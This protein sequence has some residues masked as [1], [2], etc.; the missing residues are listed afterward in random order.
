MTGISP[1][2]FDSSR[3]TRFDQLVGNS[4]VLSKIRRMISTS[5]L[6][7]VVFLTG[8]T[9]AG[10][11]TLARIIARALLCN[12]RPTGQYESCG[13]C[14]SCKKDFSDYRGNHCDYQE[15]CANRVD[16][17]FMHENLPSLLS[18]DYCVTFI[19]EIQD[20]SSSDMR[21]L[22][23]QIEGAVGTLIL[24]TTH[25]DLIEDAVRNRLKSYEYT[26]IRPTTSEIADFLAGVFQKLG[27]TYSGRVE[28][29]RVANFYKCEMR[30]CGEFP[31]KVLREY[32]TELTS[33]YLND[34]LGPA[35]VETQVSKK[36]TRRVI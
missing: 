26:L 3:P 24:A 16:A 32:G 5:S 21:L 11:T 19:D 31:Y 4:M 8:S 17:H 30:P 7:N 2:T 28:L 6:P 35:P 14:E 34:I 12:S 29:E 13:T 20:L 23:K 33:E 36:F 18:R 1:K 27:I 9:G 10:K 25:P 22:R 15:I